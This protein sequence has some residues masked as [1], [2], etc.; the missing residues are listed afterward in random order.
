[1]AMVPT[2][3]MGAVGG[4][5]KPTEGSLHDPASVDPSKSSAQLYNGKTIVHRETD[6]RQI[7]TPR[8]GLSRN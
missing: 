3:V 4:S 7:D 8:C 1:M 2:L 5:W 6:V